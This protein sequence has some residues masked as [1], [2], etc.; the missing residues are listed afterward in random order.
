MRVIRS[1]AH[2]VTRV[3]SWC[4]YL[5]LLTML[6]IIVADVIGRTLFSSP[7]STATEFSGYALVG[8]IFLG[9][10]EADRVGRHIR[11]ELVLR[12]LSK[13]SRLIVD[14]LLIAFAAIAFGGIAWLSAQP[15]LIDFSIG[16]ISITGS[17]VPLWIPEAFI[18]IGFAA[19]SLRL[20]ARVFVDLPEDMNSSEGGL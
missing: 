5:G 9:L 13:K 10:A 7:V 17:N 18:P 14:R 12:I 16:T 11:I 15:S 2:I 1:V 8:I 3:S 19:L 20:F 6:V 4:G